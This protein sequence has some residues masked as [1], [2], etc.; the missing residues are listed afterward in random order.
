[1]TKKLNKPTKIFL[2]DMEF[3]LHD[4]IVDVMERYGYDL[5]KAKNLIFGLVEIQANEI[6]EE[7]E[8]NEN[9]A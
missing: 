6:Q 8:A 5:E 2:V 9:N 1:M 7:M 4:L 3:M